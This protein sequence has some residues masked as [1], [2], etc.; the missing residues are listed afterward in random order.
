[1]MSSYRTTE[2][3]IR[4]RILYSR[5]FLRLAGKTQVYET[6]I[7]DH[8][9]TRLTHSLE[10]AQI[11]RTIVEGVNKKLEETGLDKHIDVNLIEAIALGH[12]IGHTPFGHAG[13]RQLDELL[14]FKDDK[15]IDLL[16]RGL[17]DSENDEKFCYCIS[18]N[19]L[20]DNTGFK[21]N[22]QSIRIL[23]F[24]C[25]EYVGGNMFNDCYLADDIEKRKKV[26][27]GILKHSKVK[28]DCNIYYRKSMGSDFDFIKNIQTEVEL[29]KEPIYV[30]IV[31]LADEIAQ[32]H[33]DIEDAVTYGHLTPNEVVHRLWG[34]CSKDL[35][36]EFKALKNIFENKT[37]DKAFFLKNLSS[38]IV[39]CLVGGLVERYD[40]KESLYNEEWNKINE[41][42]ENQVKEVI[43]LSQDVKRMDSRGQWIIRHL[44]K[45]YLDNPLQMPDDTLNSVFREYLRQYIWEENEKFF[46][47][48][49]EEKDAI[50]K[51]LKSDSGY[52]IFADKT[53]C[54]TAFDYVN[55]IGEKKKNLVIKNDKLYLKEKKKLGDDE[56]IVRL[57]VFAFR[58]CLA[59]VIADYIAG[60]TDTYA[61]KKFEDLFVPKS[62]NF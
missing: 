25:K 46:S 59:R 1:M 52:F 33:H 3:R 22:W 60:M 11:A 12:D 2:M 53:M 13:E 21:H 42:I 10:V 43:L 51:V 28:V 37:N 19:Y 55:A 5:S 27:E 62:W 38:V 50:N 39:N 34:E 30:Q 40:G 9:R 16:K 18:Y 4:D 29:N 58:I 24:L 17:E 45:A 57:N 48:K 41:H 32:R 15:I 56:V 47:W 36:T 54:R 6:N 26:L 8:T 23:H 31:N 20:E 61:V 14:Q 49:A 44:F 35:N 7:D